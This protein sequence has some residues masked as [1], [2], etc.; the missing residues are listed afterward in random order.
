M[1]CGA[2][3]TR[4]KRLDLDMMDDAVKIMAKMYIYKGHGFHNEESRY[5]LSRKMEKLYLYDCV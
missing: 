1:A 3:D 2:N 4:E 5:D